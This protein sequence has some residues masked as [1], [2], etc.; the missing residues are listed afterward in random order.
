MLTKTE[1]SYRRPSETLSGDVGA[2]FIQTYT[3]FSSQTDS[4]NPTATFQLPGTHKSRLKF[5][6]GLIDR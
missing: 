2:S 5:H 6:S 1:R 3:I 4:T